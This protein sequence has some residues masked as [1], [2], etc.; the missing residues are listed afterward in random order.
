MAD[1]QQV[2]YVTVGLGKRGSLYTYKA[3]GDVGPGSQVWVKTI[4]GVRPATV[5]ASSAL[6]PS[7]EPAPDGYKGR[8]V[9]VLR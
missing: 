9:D 8:T 5:V 2:S 6:P 1:K 3:V 4:N 7:K